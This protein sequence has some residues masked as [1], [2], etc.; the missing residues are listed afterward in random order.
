[1]NPKST[2]I[3]V[4]NKIFLSVTLLFA[5][6]VYA[7]DELFYASDE[8]LF[9]MASKLDEYFETAERGDV[10]TQYLL[11]L[12]YKD[13]K[14]V[15]KNDAEA[16]RWLS[17]AVEHEHV[18]AQIAL[19]YMYSKGEGVDES[20]PEAIQWYRKAADRA[21]KQ[22][23]SDLTYFFGIA[24]IRSRSPDI[25]EAKRRAASNYLEAA[26][27]GHGIAQ[28]NLG[29]MYYRGMA[30]FASDEAEAVYWFRKSAEQGNA[31]AQLKLG[32][33]Y[34]LGMGVP[35]DYVEAVRWISEAAELGQ[36]VAQ[37]NLGRIYADGDWV[38]EDDLEAV[39]WIRK[40]AE[41]GSAI[42][43]YSLA[44]LFENGEGVVKDVVQAYAWISI[45]AARGDEQFQ[46][47]K[48]RI[49]EGMTNGEITKA[50][51]LSREL[52]HRYGFAD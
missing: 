17:R 23:R 38:A 6:S 44:Q 39:R 4:M 11:G 18:E 42:G 15:P 27:L 12:M 31:D 30:G 29:L 34:A 47:E 28:F 8:L 46:V 2:G 50:R 1:M 43:Q 37:V 33:M 26:N 51:K 5:Y 40:A 22:K 16:V 21:K 36:V 49:S 48:K 45:A 10:D 3:P 41:Q 32:E 14:V 35:V 52:S 24:A 25:F 9:R 20:D 13:G 19:G 7:S